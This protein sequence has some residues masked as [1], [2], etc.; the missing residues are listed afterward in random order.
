MPGPSVRPSVAHALP[1]NVGH[2]D[3]EG[4]R[5]AGK[6]GQPGKEK[7]DETTTD[8]RTKSVCVGR[9]KKDFAMIRGGPPPLSF[10]LWLRADIA[11]IFGLGRDIPQELPSDALYVVIV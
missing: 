11:E 4:A 6:A 7:E 5:E 3:R 8:G 1:W 9:R 2:Q 10:P